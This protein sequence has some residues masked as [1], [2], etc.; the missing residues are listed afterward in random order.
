HT[1]TD[2]AGGVTTFKQTIRGKPYEASYPDGTKEFWEYDLLGNLIRHTDKGGLTQEYVYDYKGRVIEEKLLDNDGKVIYTKTK[3]YTPFHLLSETDEMGITMSYEYNF[4]GQLIRSERNGLE[5]KFIYNA[6][7]RLAKK[8][9]QNALVE[10]FDYDP[11]GRVV[12]ETK[13]DIEGNLL[14]SS[15]K[16][17]DD[18]GRVISETKGNFTTFFIYNSKGELIEKIAPDG[19]KS[20]FEY[21]HNH[22]NDLGQTVLLK[23]AIDLTGS[24]SEVEFDHLKREVRSARYDPFGKLVQQSFKTYDLL[25][26]L[27]S[28]KEDVFWQGKKEKEIE[29]TFSYD[30]MGRPKEV[31]QEKG[32]LY[33]R[34][35]FT[36]YNTLGQKIRVTKPNGVEIFYVYDAMGRVREEK[37][38]DGTVDYL[39]DYDPLSRPV[40]VLD[41]VHGTESAYAYDEEGR[42]IKEKLG[43]Q[44]SLE[45]RYDS[46]GRLIEVNHSRVDPIHLSY[47]ALYLREVQWK[48]LRSKYEAYDLAGNL[49]HGNETRYS[50]DKANRMT[51]WKRG[52]FEENLSYD[53]GGNLAQRNLL[54]LETSYTYDELNQL[55]EETGASNKT[56][57][58]DSH[59]T[60]RSK[61]GANYT[62]DELN[63]P[64]AFM[65]SEYEWDRNGNLIAR[66]ENGEKTTLRYDAR[67]RLIAIDVNGKDISYLWDEQN[68]CLKAGERHFLYQGHAEVG[69]VI[70]NKLQDFRVLGL[71]RGQEASA[72]VWVQIQDALFKPL[73]DLSGN[74]IALTDLDDTLI[75]YNPLTAFGESLTDSPSLCSPLCPWGFSSKRLEENSGLILFG[76]R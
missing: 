41:R 5:T 4:K 60:R 27:A 20:R 32:S 52:E 35:T 59:Y 14:L 9:T 57:S 23:K 53:N 70:D 55:K 75:E 36:E 45:N 19:K 66:T 22:L 44:E 24:V 38:S 51:G 54:G 10:T 33:E 26:N 13:E 73:H 72:S 67:D 74:M 63:H 1:L 17:Y 50:Y 71:G 18:A 15:S 65:D 43:T 56:Y 42:L 29:V 7:G 3:R 62:L 28:V 39:I 49:L 8:I 37:S 46:R 31:I 11:I 6:E 34:G 76:Y 16:V 12:A 2:P 58:S 48:A 40:R 64:T 47:D 68:R 21:D 61:D 69:S 30:P 25:G